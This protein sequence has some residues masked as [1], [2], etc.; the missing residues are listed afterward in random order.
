MQKRGGIEHAIQSSCQG[1]KSTCSLISHGNFETI[2]PS[3]RSSNFGQLPSVFFPWPENLTAMV[4]WFSQF[5]CPFRGFRCQRKIEQL[6]QLE[7]HQQQ[8][9]ST[10][11]T[12]YDGLK[13]RLGGGKRCGIHGIC[14]KIRW[15]S[16][17]SMGAQSFTSR[18]EWIMDW[19][20]GGSRPKHLLRAFLR[21]LGQSQTGWMGPVG[22][23][24]MGLWQKRD[25]RCLNGYA[26]SS[27]TVGFV[28][29]DNPRWW[30][31][32]SAG[33]FKSWGIPPGK[34]ENDGWSMD[35]AV[36]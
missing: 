33:A 28:D 25:W 13:V 15:L 29:K 3:L 18:H 1:K 20:R 19:W 9:A 5:Q 4:R 26:V 16:T 36:P 34:G 7:G 21:A 31:D 6:K 12:L 11:R 8:W 2:E 27:Y 32:A 35:L 10:A 23:R 14:S 17:G 30:N 22:L 24:I